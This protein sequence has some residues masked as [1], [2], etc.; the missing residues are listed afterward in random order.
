VS[1]R[2]STPAAGPDLDL[3]FSV[4]AGL[5]P[6]LLSQAGELADPLSGE[7]RWQAL[8]SRWLRDLIDELSPELSAGAYSLGLS[9]CDDATIAGLNASWRGVE[10]P[11]DVLAFA[12]QEEAPPR[13][14]PD[15]EEA[16]DA[17]PESLELG[18]IVISLDTAARQAVEARHSLER[19]L[20]WLASHGLLHLLGWDHPDDATLE[21]MLG[22][23]DRLLQCLP[24]Q[25]R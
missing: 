12:A 19:E 22:R 24:G 18:D 15:H 13:P 8:I 9:L 3:A 11:T 10:G 4:A 16:C 20:T 7:A 14:A 23:Q 6:A 1:A 5:E 21:A 25:R 17:G 2:I